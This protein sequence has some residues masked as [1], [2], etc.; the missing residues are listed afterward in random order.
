MRH[1]NDDLGLAWLVGINAILT[2]T[3]GK[4]VNVPPAGGHFHPLGNSMQD[5]SHKMNM[6]SR[7]MNIHLYFRASESILRSYE[8]L[9]TL[10]LI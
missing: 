4:R 5:I 6:S 2:P 7:G 9:S 10:R 1:T 8:L 3:L